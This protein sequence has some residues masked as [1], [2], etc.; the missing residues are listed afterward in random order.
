MNY[1]VLVTS[2][3]IGGGLS[4]VVLSYS[5][6]QQADDAYDK[7]MARRDM[8]FNLGTTVTRHAEKMY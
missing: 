8:V 5:T 3:T 1:Q 2:A 4:T 7:I 6:K